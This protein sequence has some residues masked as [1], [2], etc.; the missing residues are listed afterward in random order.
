MT[1]GET[2]PTIHYRE[3]LKP[4]FAVL[5]VRVSRQVAQSKNNQV[6]LTITSLHLLLSQQLLLTRK[7]LEHSG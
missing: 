4:P 2:D 6:S 5:L 1:V 7:G 3:G